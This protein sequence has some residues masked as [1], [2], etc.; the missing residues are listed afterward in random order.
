MWFYSYGGILGSFVFTIIG[1][2]TGIPAACRVAR[3]GQHFTLPHA[4]CR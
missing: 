3:D 2:C 4:A 1:F